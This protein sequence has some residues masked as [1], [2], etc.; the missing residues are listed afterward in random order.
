MAQLWQT[1]GVFANVANPLN[2]SLAGTTVTVQPGAAFVHCYYGEVQAAQAITGVGTNGTVVAQ[3]DFN[4]QTMQILYRDGVVDYGPSAST[5]YQQDT[6]KWEIPLWLV[7]GITLIDLRTMISAGA[8]CAWWNTAAGP[9]TVATSATVQ[10]NLLT[11]RVPYAGKAV[12]RGELLLT[13]PDASQAQTATCQLIYQYGVGDQQVSPAIV[14]T[15]P[16]GG[17]AGQP[18]TEALSLSGLISVTQGKKSMGWNVKAGTGVG[19]VT[20]AT[21]TASVQMVNLPATA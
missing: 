3:V 18:T 21:L 16:G 19:G 15:T 11:L 7:S 1:D 2:A 20:I 8:G 5:N 9:I 6:N 12:I 4:A 10:T 17:P 13:Y 14:P